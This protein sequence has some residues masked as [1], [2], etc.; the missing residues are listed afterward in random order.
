MKSGS[1]SPGRSRRGFTSPESPKSG[2]RRTPGS[3]NT[4][5]ARPLPR[6]ESGEGAGLLGLCDIGEDVFRGAPTTP[7]R[8]GAKAQSKAANE[9]RDC[10]GEGL[11]QQTCQLG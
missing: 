7:S 8:Q 3:K 2:G 11:R 6:L 1:S 9:S 4:A 5:V 10:L